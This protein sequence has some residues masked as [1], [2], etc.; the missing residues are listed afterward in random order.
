MGAGYSEVLSLIYSLQK[1]LHL[2]RDFVLMVA[3]RDISLQDNVF[4]G[5]M[6]HLNLEI[7]LSEKCFCALRQGNPSQ[8]QGIKECCFCRNTVLTS[9]MTGTLALKMKA[10]YLFYDGCVNLPTLLSLENCAFFQ[11]VLFMYQKSFCLQDRQK[12]MHCIHDINSLLL[13]IRMGSKSSS[14]RHLFK[15]QNVLLLRN[16]DRNDGRGPG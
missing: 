1:S 7:L 16:T 8:G 9:G 6:H 15:T 3:V 12:L 10:C 2:E 13:T 4:Q 14:A 11:W 5:L